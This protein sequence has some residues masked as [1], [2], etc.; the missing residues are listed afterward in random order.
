MVRVYTKR[1]GEQP[2]F[3]EPVILTNARGGYT[4]RQACLSLHKDILDEFASAKVWGKSVKFSPMN[5][6]LTHVLADED[7]IQ[8]LKKINKKGESH[9]IKKLVDYK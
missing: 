9:L 8:V 6:G 1:K 7:V 4:V 5:T 3:T 2:D